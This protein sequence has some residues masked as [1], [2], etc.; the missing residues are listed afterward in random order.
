MA[1]AGVPRSFPRPPR[2]L[3]HVRVCAVP[4]AYHHRARLVVRPI[5]RTRLYILPPAYGP[6]PRAWDAR[7]YWRAGWRGPRWESAPR[8]AYAREPYGQGGY[9]H[10]YDRGP[11]SGW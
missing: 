8:F 3:R 7:P 6:P 2:R 9:A 10:G 1:E 4:V 11:W 5:I